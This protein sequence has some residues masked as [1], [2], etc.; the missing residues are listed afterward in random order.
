MVALTDPDR[1]F[2]IVRQFWWHADTYLQLSEVY[3]HREE[4]SDSADLISRAMFSYER[5]LIGAFTFASG[6]N[7]LDFDRV[8]NRPFYLAVSRIIS[9]VDI[10]SCSC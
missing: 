7:R 4:H 3:R 5:A 6:S 10:L 8:E 1:F 9:C 2:L